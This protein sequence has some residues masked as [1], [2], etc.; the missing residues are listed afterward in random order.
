MAADGGLS[1]PPVPAGA[2]DAWEEASRD[3]VAEALRAK[4]ERAAAEQA[5]RAEELTVGGVIDDVLEVI[6]QAEADGIPYAEIQAFLDDYLKG[7]WGDAASPL[8]DTIFRTNVQ[9][10]FNSL[11]Y[12]RMAADTEVRP[13]WRFTAVLDKRTSAPCVSCHGTTLA[14]S[15]TWWAT[16]WPPLHH[17]CRST[18]IALTA[19]EVDVVGGVTTR[20]PISSSV[21][22]E[23]FGLVPTDSNDAPDVRASNDTANRASGGRSARGKA[24]KGLPRPPGERSF[25]E[26]VES[27][28]AHV[29]QTDETRCGP[30]CAQM[31]GDLHGLDAMTQDA[32]AAL[33]EYQ[34]GDGI[35]A[36]GLASAMQKT[37]APTGRQ[38]VAADYFPKAATPESVAEGISRA[39][40]DGG[41]AAIVNVLVKSE[42]KEYLHFV[43]I[44]R[45]EDGHVVLRDPEGTSSTRL[46]ISADGFGN[47]IWTGDVVIARLDP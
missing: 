40:A 1:A 13:Y 25:G 12:L 39:V 10:A 22:A 14:A 21:A 46:P 2:R 18:V 23:G 44:D 27:N 45:V 4:A 6:L 20:P 29:Q 36:I 38:W 16:H 8:L 3:P 30:A 5:A 47:Y 19:R 31:V 28:R 11:R 15:D 34:P 32:I 26:R 37:S 35:D 9:T 17:R 33:P 41:G 24:A 42:G 43:V 7:R